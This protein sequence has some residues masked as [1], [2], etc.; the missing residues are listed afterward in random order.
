M[1][2]LPASVAAA[3]PW[4][5]LTAAR[6]LRD[7]TQS[8]WP[9]RAAT[10]AA[11]SVGAEPLN[12][13][14]CRLFVAAPRATAANW[15]ARAAVAAPVGC[16]GMRASYTH[17]A[18][19]TSPTVAH[20]DTVLTNDTGRLR[21]KGI[22]NMAPIRRVS[23]QVTSRRKSSRTPDPGRRPASPRR[24]G[25]RAPPPRRGDGWPRRP[26]PL[27]FPGR[28]ETR[29]LRRGRAR[30]RHGG[31]PASRPAL[32]HPARAGGRTRPPR[33]CDAGPRGPRRSPRTRR[34]PA[35]QSDRR[36]VPPRR[37]SYARTQR[38][39]A[40]APETHRARPLPVSP[41]P[42]PDC[43]RRTAPDPPPRDTFG[44]PRCPADRKSTRLNSSHLVIS[45]AVFCL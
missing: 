14:M 29:R 6:P 22:E 20:R 21:A 2:R 41:F 9:P 24:S 25:R 16:D 18:A 35:G 23:K 27:R 34:R 4:R 13:T 19:A 39:H 1:P 36:T 43:P 15:G 7:A 44:S 31:G 12:V 5:P 32:R 45:Y 37:I 38:E 3:D 40:P 8:I 11:K 28:R 33:A 26:H 10:C 30:A 42:F 17:A